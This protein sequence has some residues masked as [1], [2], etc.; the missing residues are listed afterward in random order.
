[1]LLL[2]S[3]E[4][5]TEMTPYKK[6]YTAPVRQVS[7][8]G[9]NRTSG[10][11]NHET[12]A[13]GQVF[14]LKIMETTEGYDPFPSWSFDYYTKSSD[15]I[16]DVL[17]KIAAKIND[18]TAAENKQN[19]R[20][21]EAKVVSDATYG[22]FAMTG[23]TPT[24]TFTNGS[25]FVQIESAANDGAIDAAVGDFL[26]VSASATPTDAIG[27]IYKIV[28]KGAGNDAIITLDRP[29]IGT[30]IAMT[31]AQAEGTRLKEVSSVVAAGIEFTAI[32]DNVHFRVA[33]Q[34]HLI[35][36]DITYV[37]PVTYGNGTYLQVA[38]IEKEGKIFAGETTNMVAQPEK[39]GEQDTFTVVDETYD[40][41]HFNALKST[42]GI[43]V[44]AEYKSRS[45][46]VVA[47]A[48]SA[49][50]VDG[51]LNTLFGL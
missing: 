1:M 46:V 14:G 4:Y 49:G 32:E 45:N 8:I 7:A 40:F 24:L 2:E 22:N 50:N 16:L 34:E 27:D 35:D 20:L 23:T 37:T 12:L 6:L 10:S 15:T 36:A 3:S 19:K 26:S 51:T 17:I 30:T 31:E 48:K 43:G 44:Q 39:W 29:Y 41:Y 21:V 28:A 18:D 38:E 5:L 33:V 25:K 47:V 11:T 9:W 42:Q 13:A